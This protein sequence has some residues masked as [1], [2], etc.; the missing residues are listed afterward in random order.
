VKNKKLNIFI[1]VSCGLI[2]LGFV[3]FS[4]DAGALA[5]QFHR[6]RLWWVAAAVGCMIVYW[7][8]E[9][10][11]LHRMLRPA[12]PGQRFLNSF[13][14]AMG[15][16]YFNAITPFASGGQPFQAYYLTRQGVPLGVAMNA[17]LSKFIVYQAALVVVSAVLLI[18]RLDYFRLSVS[19]FSLVVLVG[20]AINLLVMAAL[21]AVALFPAFTDKLSRGIIRLLAKIRL[22]K[23]P[24]AR[25]DYMDRELRQF[26]ECFRKMTGQIPTILLA[27]ALS[28]AQLL[29]YMV[30]PYLLYRAFGLTAV[31]PLTIVAA[32]AFVMMVSA[33]IPIPG[34]GVGA[35]GFFY[36]FFQRFFTGDGQ[37][38]VALILWRVI[39]FY[40]TLV[41]GAVFTLRAGERKPPI[42]AKGS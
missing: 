9:A 34:A 26:R 23:D 25:I 21:V 22:V 27:L 13:R 33:F 40:L 17:L 28:V 15:G 20:F 3:F 39:T 6:L 7:L 4:S 10:G 2:V 30:I 19:N 5:R 8:L 32:Q 36:F 38:G 1:C 31:D 14:V 41:A 18:L 37:L 12:Y 16:Q 42:A 35:E 24:Q 11:I 29:V